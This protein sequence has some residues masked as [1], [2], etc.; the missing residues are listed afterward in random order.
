MRISI[1]EAAAHLD[2]LVLRAEAGEEIMLTEGG[3]DVVKLAATRQPLNPD[4]RRAIL[5]EISRLSA[6]KASND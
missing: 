3:R 2:E 6:A 1:A 4:E 5:E